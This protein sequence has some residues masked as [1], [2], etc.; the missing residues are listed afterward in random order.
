MQNINHHERGPTYT[1]CHQ[2]IGAEEAATVDKGGGKG[3]MLQCQPS[4]LARKYHTK[5]QTTL[6]F[7]RGLCYFKEADM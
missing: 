7:P 3:V 4:P 6:A 5:Q 1:R 2:Q